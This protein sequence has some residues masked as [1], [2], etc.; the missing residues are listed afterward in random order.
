MTLVDESRVTWDQ[1]L[2]E[3]E[4]RRCFPATRDPN[5]LLDAFEYFCATYCYIKHPERGRI[6][7]LLF[8]AQ[9]ETA[10]M[11]MTNRYSLILK[12]RQLG[13]S[14]LVAVYTLWLAFGWDDRVV[15]MLSRTERDAIK[16]LSKAKYSFRFLP[17]WMKWRGPAMNATQTKMEFTN[18]SYLESL[19][20]ASDPARGES[21][22]LAVIDELAYLPNSDEAWASIEPIADVGGRV[23]AL[24]TA[25]GE[26]NLFHNL[27]VGASKGLNRFTNIFHPWWA[28]GRDRAWYEMKKADL[29]EWQLAQEYPEDPE[30]AFLKSGRPVFSLETLK[31]IRCLP[32][33]QRGYFDIARGLQFVEESGSPLRIWN[34][35]AAD[36]RYAVGCDVSEGLEHGD[37]SSAHVINARTGEVVAHWHGR[38]DPDLLGTQ[39]L[40]PLGRWYNNALVGVESN[41]HGL[42]TLKAL[43]RGRYH[44]IFMQRSPRYKKSVPTDILGWRTTQITKPLAVDELNMALREGSVLLRDAETVSE[45]RTFVRDEA[46][47]MHGSPFDDRTISLSIANQMLKHVWLKQF[48]P[49]RDPPP[50]TM[51]YME[52]MLYGRDLGSDL[53]SRRKIPD[54]REPIGSNFVRRT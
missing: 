19:P 48:E 27:W 49:V 8:D 2:E 35:P 30:E 37:F 21:V 52:K 39:V 13:F 45:L 41:N 29:P 17:E 47:R 33:L 10:S 54:Q 36:G 53:S 23:I 46:G 43:Q 11:W 16:L 7:F 14:T 32:P 12:A 42:T 26:G 20:S 6:K 1:L 50:G 5:K 40:I 3:R 44:P 9:R 51:G 24:S 31:S 15:I 18:E 22:Y 4:W 38:I 25:N 28:N 34:F